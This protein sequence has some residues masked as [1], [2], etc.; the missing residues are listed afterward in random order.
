MGLCPPENQLSE[1]QTAGS[2][3]AGVWQYKSVVVGMTVKRYA[4]ADSGTRLISA[5]VIQRIY[6]PPPT[7]VVTAAVPGLPVK[8]QRVIPVTLSEP[9]MHRHD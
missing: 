3:S 7:E 2:G 8:L 6:R 5:A 4:V 9:L 1:S